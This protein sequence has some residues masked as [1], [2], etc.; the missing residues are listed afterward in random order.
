[1]NCLACNNTKIAL[2]GSKALLFARSVTFF[3]ALA[4]D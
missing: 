3:I 2:I 1:M 4:N